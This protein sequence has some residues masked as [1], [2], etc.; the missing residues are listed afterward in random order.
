MNCSLQKRDIVMQNFKNLVKRY[1]PASIIKKY[2]DNQPWNA[3]DILTAPMYEEMKGT[4]FE[5]QV[6]GNFNSVICN[7][8]IKNL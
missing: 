5:N 3:Y 4:R 7:W 2:A 6:S 1:I 8:Y